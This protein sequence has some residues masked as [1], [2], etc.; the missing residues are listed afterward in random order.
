MAVKGYIMQL[1]PFSV[2]DGDGIRT[3]IFLAGCPLRCKWCSNPEGFSRKPLIGWYQRKCIGC[4]ACTAVCPEHIGINMNLEREKCIACGKCTEICPKGA[5]A[6]M[7]SLADADDILTQIRKHEIF[8][9]Y[10]GGGVTF[11]GGE[12]TSQPELLNYLTSKIYDMNISMD[13]E[14]CGHFEFES[15][16]ESLERLDLIFMDL[17]MMDDDKHKLYTGVSNEMTLKNIKKLSEVP[18]DV[19]IR[20]PVIGGVNNDEDNIRRSAEYVHNNLPK[21]KMELLPYHKFGT[22]KYEAI[23][24]PYEHDD[25]YRPSKEEMEKLRELVRSEG[26]ETADFT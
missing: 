16:R 12:A 11:S 24:M 4:G 25:F 17:K 20:I 22:I 2:N 3:T 5:R 15:V 21:A 7:V 19:V 6:K 14:S 13:I 26:V 1:Q 9:R 8:Y 23:G 10:S 18:A